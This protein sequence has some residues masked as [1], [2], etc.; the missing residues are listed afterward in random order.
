MWS[1]GHTKKFDKWQ[2]FFN[3]LFN[4][5]QGA[6]E[7][8]A[9]VRWAPT[10]H[11]TKTSILQNKNLYIHQWALDANERDGD[12]PACAG[13]THATKHKHAYDKIEICIL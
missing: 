2:P 13:C 12:A 11:K 9:S 6:L 3:F 10:Y 7:R 8:C 4:H 5:A 1:Y